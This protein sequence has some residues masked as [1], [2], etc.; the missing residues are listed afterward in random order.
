MET[1][2]F[3]G[4][5]D[6]AAE[7]IK[8]GGLV[9]VPTETVYGLAGNGLDEEAVKQI[10]EVKGRPQVKPLSLMV[11]GAEAMDRY[12]EDVPQGARLL[13]ERFWPGP[14]TIVLKAKD[15]IP[16]IVL[17]GG[18]TVGL[19]CPDHPM[20]LEL[21][22]KAGVPFAAPS[23]N[24]SGEESPKTAQKVWDYFS[25][26]IEGI[27][28]G[29]ECGIGRESTIISMAQKPYRIL[30]QGALA[31][32]EIASALTEGLTILGI[33]GGTGCGKT[34]ALRTLEELGALIIDCDAVYHG[35]LI[36]N[37]EMLAEIDSAFPGVV[38]GGVL[39]RKALGAVVFSDAEA[40]ARLNGIT[41]SYVGR[42]IDRLL[43]SWAM[44]GGRLA[45]IDAIE[46]FGGN[47]S[48]C[49]KATFAV[50]ADRDKRI[51]R[52]MARD[53]ITREYAALRVDVQKPDSY[54]EEKCDYILKNNSTEEEFREKCRSKF[55]EVID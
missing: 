15:F 13:A 52:I 34:T 35:L 9:A 51:E 29:G 28:N 11:P 31:E 55:L 50:L 18:D 38:I 48:G 44:S 40:L 46:L 27:I 49:C 42:E 1:K 43:E 45:A 26:R 30:R 32:K 14:L 36:E 25:G 16:S 6:E 47:L 24:P 53:G 22:K 39:D 2:I 33:T 21:L 8:T 5:A 4:A 7:I 3:H 54:F 23:A 12:C 19:R 10:Y 37:K 20:T 17:A 41:H